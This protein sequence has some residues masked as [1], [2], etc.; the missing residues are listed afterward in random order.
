MVFILLK[1][2]SRHTSIYFLGR[3]LPQGKMQ[4]SVHKLN[5][6]FESDDA[7][8]P[9][10]L[11]AS[12]DKNIILIVFFY[13]F[14]SLFV[15]W[16]FFGRGQ[17][18]DWSFYGKLWSILIFFLFLSYLS[19]CQSNPRNVFQIDPHYLFCLTLFT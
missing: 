8:L 6:Y 12:M 16:G 3:T 11:Y 15:S 7:Q 18:G 19:Y 9:R 13:L 4:Y 5:I 17:V 14:V 10:N 2:C 1:V